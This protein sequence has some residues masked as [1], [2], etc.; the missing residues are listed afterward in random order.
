[1]YR[2]RIVVVV[3]A[4]YVSS[5]VLLAILVLLERVIIRRTVVNTESPNE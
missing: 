3:R 4:R 5:F 2:I 1:M